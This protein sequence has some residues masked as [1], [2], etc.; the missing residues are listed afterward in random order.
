MK[1]VKTLLA[2][3]GGIVVLGVVIALASGGGDK[4]P[5]VAAAT[6]ISEPVAEPGR[7]QP[8]AARAPRPAAPAPSAMSDKGW[9]VVK[10]SVL[11][12]EDGIGDFDGTARI[13]NQND[14]EQSGSF[15]FTVF[16]GSQQ[17]ATLSG[18]ASQV[19]PGQTMTV[20]LFTTDD[21]VPGQSRVVFQTDY[22]F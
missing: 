1:I 3:I 2:V 10:G 8:E 12:S 13:T 4:K 15:T 21:Y 17:V 9:T 7:S 16:H 5:S 18:S 6:P 22:S 11:I 14:S 19:Q 20:T